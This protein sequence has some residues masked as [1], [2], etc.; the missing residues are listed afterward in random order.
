MKVWRFYKKPT[1]GDE[2]PEGISEE[3]KFPLYAITND[4]KLAKE[5]MRTRN[6]DIFMVKKNTEVSKSEYADLA[7]KYRSAVL[8]KKDLLTSKDK[9]TDKQE[10]YEIPVVMTVFE[11]ITVEE[12]VLPIDDE[13]TWMTLM[14][15]PYIFN[16]KILKALK[17][18]DYEQKYRI[19]KLDFSHVSGDEAYETPSYYVDTVEFFVE[20][21]GETLK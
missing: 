15:S 14:P 11:K 4:K 13:Q 18:L 19:F 17:L 3:D 5:F 8:I 21:F 6:M 9:Y 20:T 7:N 12:P 10:V 16:N 2:I 1:K